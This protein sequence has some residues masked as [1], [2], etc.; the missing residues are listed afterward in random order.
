MRESLVSKSGLDGKSAEYST[1]S[2]CRIGQQSICKQTNKQT[3]RIHYR[4]RHLRTYVRTMVVLRIFRTPHLRAY[5][6]LDYVCTYVCAYVVP[7]LHYLTHEIG[8]LPVR[9][10]VGHLQEPADVI[11]MVGGLVEGEEVS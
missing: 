1:L 5:V 7:H 9:L 4:T 3:L 8:G 10:L 2:S 11:T 6:H